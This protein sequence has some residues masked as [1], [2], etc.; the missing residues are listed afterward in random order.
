MARVRRIPTENLTAYDLYLHGLDASLRAFSETKRELNV[1]AQRQFEQ[2]LVLDPHYAQAYAGLSWVYYLDWFMQWSSEPA[3]AMARAL[4]MARR[5]IALDDSLPMP[6]SMVGIIYA[7]QKQYGQALAAGRRAIAVDSNFADGYVNLGFI[8][9]AAGRPEEAIGVIE[10]AMRLN[11]RYPVRYLLTLGFAYR[12]G[13]RCE[14]AITVTRQF[15]AVTPHVGPAHM[16]LAACYAVLGRLEE[17]WGE[18]AEVVRLQPYMSLEWLRQN[19]PAMAER[20]LD[21]LRKAGLK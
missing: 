16:T 2:A 4:E 17:A 15:L 12:D 10:Q 3:R 6:H 1:Q 8:L 9:V 21:T 19:W 18:M 7:S 14:E 11:P 5:A 20:H 13:G